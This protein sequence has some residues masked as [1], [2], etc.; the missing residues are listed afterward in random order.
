MTASRL[1]AALA[2]YERWWKWEKV[3]PDPNGLN[4][5]GWLDGD[6]DE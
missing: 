1:K 5:W 3:P 6:D 4:D 2:E